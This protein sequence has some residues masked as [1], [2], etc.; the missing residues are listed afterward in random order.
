[1]AVDQLQEIVPLH[2]ATASETSNPFVVLPGPVTGDTFYT[3]YRVRIQFSD[4]LQASG[5][6]VW[7][8]NVQISYNKG[9]SWV[10]N[11]SGT[12][13][14]LSTTAQDG[15]QTLNV[16]PNLPTNCGQIWLWVLA[17]LSGSPV[18]ATIAYRA[19]LQLP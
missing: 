16:N 12:A 14:T 4:A 11:V 13:I 6:G 7:T 18:S 10:T 19:D 3:P 8:F 15:Q 17:T 9:G 2:I 1:M 5:A